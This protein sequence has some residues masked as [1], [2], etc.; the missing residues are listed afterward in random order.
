MLWLQALY[1]VYCGVS[2]LLLPNIMARVLK[3]FKVQFV[4]SE[5]LYCY[6]H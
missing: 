5:D 3:Q 2:V 6:K 1:S 4:V